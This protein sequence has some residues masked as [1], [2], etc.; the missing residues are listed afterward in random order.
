METIYSKNDFIEKENQEALN[1]INGTNKLCV[2]FDISC[3]EIN[4]AWGIW[5]SYDDDEFLVNPLDLV[6]SIFEDN[7]YYILEKR[8]NPENLVYHV[9]IRMEG[10]CYTWRIFNPNEPKVTC[11]TF[12]L[13]DYIDSIRMCVDSLCNVWENGA[14]TAYTDSLDFKLEGIKMCKKQ[15]E[16]K[17]VTPGYY[18]LMTKDI[19]SEIFTFHPV[20]DKFVEEYTIGIG[21]RKYDTF[22][23]HW[24]NDYEQIRH[25]LEMLAY[26]Q[27][28]EIDLSFDMSESILKIER[29]SVLDQMMKDGDGTGFKYKEYALVEIFPNEFTRMPIIK[30]YC[31]YKET[32]KTFYEGLLRLAMAHSEAGYL[33]DHEPPR[34]VAYNKFKSPIIENII[35]GNLRDDSIAETRQCNI[36]TI[37]TIDPDVDQ[38]FIDQEGCSYSF[39]SDGLLDDDDICDRESKPI[40]MKEMYEWQSEIVPIVIASETGQPYSKDWKDYHKRGLKLAHELRNRLSPNIDLWYVAPFED[41]SGFIDHPILVL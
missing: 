11:M 33:Q 34:M 20:K 14:D 7:T 29:R 21:D 17:G 25:Q 27:K 5:F 30:G 15:M 31:D 19:K 40:C 38:V 37:L 4:G 26:T 12:S 32:V 2:K 18:R 41:K 36:K 23:T 10:F 22:L 6:N 35:I 3:K 9:G 8:T 16:V 13:H 28:A 24:D 39:D 1:E